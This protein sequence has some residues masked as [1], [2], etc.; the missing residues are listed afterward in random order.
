MWKCR[1]C[2]RT[3][4][5]DFCICFKCNPCDNLIRQNIRHIT[6]YIYNIICSTSP[7]C[8]IVITIKRYSH[9]ESFRAG[10]ENLPII[11]C[12]NVNT[13]ILYL[14]EW[15]IISSKLNIGFEWCFHDGSRW[16][17]RHLWKTVFT[18]QILKLCKNIFSYNGGKILNFLITLYQF[19]CKSSIASSS[20]NTKMPCYLFY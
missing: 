18:V 12:L 6:V 5:T 10:F 11:L 1:C 20:S 13:V 7:L 16:I 4:H 2:H 3:T 14:P 9:T 15:N 17:Q 8:S 19:Y